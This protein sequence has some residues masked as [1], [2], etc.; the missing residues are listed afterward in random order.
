[1]RLMALLNLAGQYEGQEL[2]F[3]TIEAEL[4]LGKDE[5]E[6]WVVRAFGKQLLEG[7]INQV[8]SQ[9]CTVAAP[10]RALTLLLS[11]TLHL[12]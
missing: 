9:H 12:V 5:A 4:G 7:R 1:M 11:P 3:E 2:E 10:S 8:R 6:T